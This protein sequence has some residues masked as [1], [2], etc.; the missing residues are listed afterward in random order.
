[1]SPKR[2]PST[3]IIN[4]VINN[5]ENILSDQLITQNPGLMSGFTTEQVI[6]L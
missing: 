2:V 3:D 5:H 4:I 1:M 6:S